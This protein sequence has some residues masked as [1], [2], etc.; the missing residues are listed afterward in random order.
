[1][2]GSVQSFFEQGLAPSTRKTYAA[3]SKWFYN[4]C[5]K[6]HLLS[7]FPVTEHTLCCFAAFLVDEGLTPQTARS[8]LAAMRNLQLFLGLPYPRG[9]SHLFLF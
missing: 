8:Y 2:A 4:F 3:A 1:M 7:P 5:T 6:F 9:T